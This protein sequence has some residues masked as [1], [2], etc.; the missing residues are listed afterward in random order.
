MQKFKN[1]IRWKRKKKINLGRGISK[2]SQK[3]RK[4]MM[5][6]KITLHVTKKE[7]AREVRVQLLT[8]E[9][10]DILV[11]I[12]ATTQIHKMIFSI[13]QVHISIKLV[14]IM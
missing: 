1:V 13:Q 4:N 9:I 2:L 12:A 14:I 8:L 5:M 6:K 11:E 7:G 10:V 3:M